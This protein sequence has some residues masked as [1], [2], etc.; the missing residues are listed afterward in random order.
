MSTLIR[1]FIFTHFAGVHLICPIP[2]KMKYRLLIL[3]AALAI[4]VSAFEVAK[5]DTF[6]RKIDSINYYLR[7]YDTLSPFAEYD[8]RFSLIESVQEKIISGLIDVLNDQKIQKYDLNNTFDPNFLYHNSSADGRVHFFTID[9][10]NG[11]SWRMQRTILHTR[12]KDGTVRAAELGE[13]YAYASFGDVQLVDSTS[14]TYIAI[15]GVQTCNTCIA[16]M[17][18][19]IQPDSASAPEIIC[20][21]DS[22]TV[23]EYD[24]VY[25]PLT[26]TIFCQH[27]IRTNDPLSGSPD[28]SFE[29]G[30]EQFSEQPQKITFQNE[31][32]FRHGKFV[33]IKA[34]WSSEEI[35]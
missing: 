28:D 15:G 22:R 13:N 27:S 20:S 24:M 30:E 21:F 3:F 32:A 12:L 33:R 11:G 34:C 29:D 10:K 5:K 35:E 17:A 23:D 14:A 26:K 8:D 25:D 19:V 2:S 16:M 6:Q 18:L 1:C 9:A 31:F 4:K 7:I